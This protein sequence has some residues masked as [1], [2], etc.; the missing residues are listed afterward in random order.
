MSGRRYW[1]AWISF[2]SGSLFSSMVTSPIL[3]AQDSPNPPRSSAPTPSLSQLADG[4]YQFCTK[5]DPQ[6]WQDGAGVCLN[7]VKQGASI[8][9]YYGYPHSDVFA[10]LQGELTD[11]WLNGRGLIMNWNN[12]L[13]NADIDTNPSGTSRSTTEPNVEQVEE[14]WAREG[15]LFL[16]QPEI[17]PPEAAGDDQFGWI[18][19]QQARLNVAGLYAYPSPRMTPPHQLCSWP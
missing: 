8:D 17:I 13:T 15:R 1:I 18:L 5:P 16:S 6:D 10:C 12:E 4:A 19:Y 11:G 7:F 14:A 3:L 2:M 9:G